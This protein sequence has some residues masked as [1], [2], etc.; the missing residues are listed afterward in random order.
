MAGGRKVGRKRFDLAGDGFLLQCTRKETK[1]D[2]NGEVYEVEQHG[3][4]CA[5]CDGGHQWKKDGTY[6]AVRAMDHLAKCSKIPPVI[7]NGATIKQ[8]YRR[9]K[10]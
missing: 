6:L 3:W 9:I 1:I 4:K 8:Y 2:E 7:L 5:F 10:T